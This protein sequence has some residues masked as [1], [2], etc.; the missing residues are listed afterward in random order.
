MGLYLETNVWSLQV[1]VQEPQKMNLGRYLRL[2]QAV[3]VLLG[4]KCMLQLLHNISI[5]FPLK[6]LLMS[7]LLGRTEE[8]FSTPP[9]ISNIN[10]VA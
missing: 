1:Q 2:R 9:S 5:P 8:T 6:L 7:W 4:K 3:P 10:I